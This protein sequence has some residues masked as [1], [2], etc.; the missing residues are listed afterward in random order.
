MLIPSYRFFCRVVWMAGALGAFG[1]A[2]PVPDGGTDGSVT[3]AIEGG[4]LDTE[5]DSVFALIARHSRGFSSCTATLIAPNVLLTAQHCVTMNRDAPVV[6]G[7][8]E[9]GRQYDPEILFASNPVLLGEQTSWFAGSAIRVPR[10]G[11]DTCGFDVALVMLAK[12]VPAEMATPAVPRIDRAVEQGELYAAV[13]YGVDGNGEPQGGRQ[14]RSD[15]RIACTPGECGRRAVISEF[16]GEAGVCSGDSGGP[17][18]D[19]QGK[20]VGIV[21]RGA[22]DCSF[23]IYGAVAAWRDMIVEFVE[24]AAVFGRYEPPFW[25]RTGAS[26]PPPPVIVEPGSACGPGFECSEGHVCFEEI[27]VAACTD[28]DGCETGFTCQT[29]ESAPAQALCLPEPEPAP[30]EPVNSAPKAS[31][32]YRAGGRSQALPLAALGLAF[33]LATRRGR[34]RRRAER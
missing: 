1:C 11:S 12:N 32:A 24:Q 10:E 9:L 17:A 26:D 13:G 5:H 30:A 16:V 28:D 27:C 31:C 33:A 23:P 2:A 22:D 6:C 19:A 25:V 18:F 8:A 34:R 29:A 21:S 3:S 7:Q 15:L 14:V 4:A 20:L